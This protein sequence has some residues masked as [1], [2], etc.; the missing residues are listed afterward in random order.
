M[1]T[2]HRR[3]GVWPGG[4]PQAPAT[5]GDLIQVPAGWPFGEQKRESMSSPPN[6]IPL[7]SKSVHGVLSKVR[8]L[9]VILASPN[10]SGH[11]LAELFHQLVGSDR[12]LI[13]RVIQSQG[14]IA[15][16]SAR[17]AIGQPPSAMASERRTPVVQPCQPPRGTP[18]VQPPPPQP[19]R[20]PPQ[21]SV[22]APSVVPSP[23]ALL[24]PAALQL[25]SVLPGA[26]PP[27]PPPPP[28]GLPAAAAPPASKPALDPA[29]ANYRPTTAATGETAATG[30]ERQSLG[31]VIG[32]LTVPGLYNTT[33]GYILNIKG[34]RV[35]ALG[36]PLRPRGVA[37]GV[38]RHQARQ[39][40]EGRWWQDPNTRQWY[41]Q[42]D[43]NGRWVKSGGW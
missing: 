15:T 6:W 10:D 39:T 8:I 11:A 36:R 41:F 5:A 37:V 2:G 27:P 26:I 3:H 20:P 17:A 23:A 35:D 12:N 9:P 24:S 34:E 25:P 28:P 22:P 43:A 7:S 32:E 29:G 16:T 18:V 13:S 21:N 19:K 30:A 33:K 4:Q 14:A 40:N 1:S 42:L 31:E 38:Q